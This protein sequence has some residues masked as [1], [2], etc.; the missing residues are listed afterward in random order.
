M[1]S[2]DRCY[3]GFWGCLIIA[4]IHYAN[5]ALLAAGGFFGLA[6]LAYTWSKKK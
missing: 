3:I 2:P 4:H 6:A 5:G 1:S